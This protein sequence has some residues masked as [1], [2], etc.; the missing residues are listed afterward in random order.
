[1]HSTEVNQ[2]SHLISSHLLDNVPYFCVFYCVVLYCTVL[3][4]TVLYV[5][6]QT[7][8]IYRQK[9][10][11]NAGAVL[12]LP[13]KIN[14]KIQQ[15]LYRIVDGTLPVVD[16]V[17]RDSPLVLS[18]SS[19][20]SSSLD[21][22]GVRES[23][24][25]VGSN[26]PTV[27]ESINIPTVSLEMTSFYRNR[28]YGDSSTSLLAGMYTSW[29]PDKGFVMTKE[30]ILRSAS[31]FTNLRLEFNY[32]ANEHGAWK[33]MDSLEKNNL[34]QRKRGMMGTKH[35]FTLTKEGL[36][37]CHSLFT[38]KIH[39]HFN[40]AEKVIEPQYSMVDSDGNVR[41]KTDTLS[42]SSGPSTFEL[43]KQ[44][45][46]NES[47]WLGLDDD[48]IYVNSTPVFQGHDGDADPWQSLGSSS[49]Q[50]SD[51]DTPIPDPATVRA[52]R[53]SLLEGT[54]RT[55]NA[56]ASS[57]LNVDGSE[58]L[59]LQ[60][61][62][63][64]SATDAEVVGKYESEDDDEELGR[65]LQLSK[66]DVSRSEHGI[67]NSSQDELN[68]ALA[69]SLSNHHHDDNDHQNIS[70]HLATLE[71]QQYD[72]ALKLSRITSS[73]QDYNRDSEKRQNIEEE[74]DDDDIHLVDIAEI[75]RWQCEKA[76]RM[77]MLES[78]PILCD[79]EDNH[80]DSI[81]RRRKRPRDGLET[82]D[83]A[84][85]PQ[86]CTT[87][88]SRT[89]SY[90]S[91]KSN[92]DDDDAILDLTVADENAVDSGAEMKSALTPR[93]NPLSAVVVL[94]CLDL[95]NIGSSP[96]NLRKEDATKK[97]NYNYKKSDSCSV[98]NVDFVKDIE[99]IDVTESAPNSAENSPLLLPDST[100]FPA[101]ISK[102]FTQNRANSE[103]YLSSVDGDFNNGDSIEGFTM[104]VDNAE[105]ISQNTYRQFYERIRYYI[106]ELIP[107]YHVDRRRLTVGDFQCTVDRNTVT[108]AL[109]FIVERKTI[110]DIVSRSNDT[111]SS[112]SLMAPHFKQAM[113]LRH[114]GLAHPFF[115]IE[116]D[117]S[118]VSGYHHAKVDY[119]G[120]QSVDMISDEQELTSFF[121]R[122]IS[123]EWSSCKVMMLQTWHPNSTAMLLVCMSFYARKCYESWKQLNDKQ[124]CSADI[125]FG[126]YP[127]VNCFRKDLVTAVTAKSLYNDLRQ[128]GVHV[129]MCA[130]VARRYPE[131]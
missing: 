73:A 86:L 38:K 105:R 97:Y 59:M 66:Q 34:V 123:H 2:L 24:K 117:T 63:K 58:E 68:V 43:E 41:P 93:H 106:Q 36:K 19:S 110:N 100:N 21:F 51:H 17:V 3:Y 18:S 28:K 80:C 114:C 109:D 42:S 22:Q 4:C 15:I 29:R 128:E 116:G 56:G 111:K 85:H 107:V 6:I 90:A 96:H 67:N 45:Q 53:C 122:M 16:A 98:S 10:G 48:E 87:K 20:S 104:V 47:K 127:S 44:W 77:S 99:T 23:S 25:S 54:P 81:R 130:R 40:S 124:P 50:G 9:T 112:S 61:A 126:K 113:T 118:K 62:L 37:F 31:R 27:E 108:Y 70:N 119:V 79:E 39:P 83:S 89:Y 74:E 92:H 91:S 35:E 32:R 64:M 71:E 82:G 121:A 13:P 60:R 55:R 8:T 1:M 125:L 14:P 115:L 72:E 5:F 95:S 52:L 101:S 75:E 103:N 33:S 12:N 88:K 129:E 7:G 131:L 65:V 46:Q 57:N 30:H 69:M 120:Q 49:L 76:M 94:P 84:Q 26:A 102:N 11:E 78:T